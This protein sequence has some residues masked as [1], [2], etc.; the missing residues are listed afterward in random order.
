MVKVILLESY[1]LE[2]YPL[3]TSGKGLVHAWSWYY[4]LINYKS[5]Q[6][7]I[8]YNARSKRYTNIMQ[9][10]LIIVNKNSNNNTNMVNYRAFSSVSY[11]KS[12]VNNNL[13]IRS[14]NQTALILRVDIKPNLKL[15]TLDVRH[16]SS[17]SSFSNLNKKKL[18]LIFTKQTLFKHFS[19][20]DVCYGLVVI[21]I[22]ASIRYSGVVEI[23]LVFLFDSSPEWAQLALASALVLP[24][25]LGL[26][27][28]VGDI[29]DVFDLEKDKLTMG[30][31]KPN[32]KSGFKQID[33]KNLIGNA[34]N[35]SDS[36][37]G[38]SQQG[39]G[40]DSSQQ[41]QRARVR[42]IW[43]VNY[44]QPHQVEMMI[45]SARYR[46]DYLERRIAYLSN[47]RPEGI[48]LIEYAKLKLECS[49]LKQELIQTREDLRGIH[50][51]LQMHGLLSSSRYTGEKWLR[52]YREAAEQSGNVRPM[53]NRN[54][55]DLD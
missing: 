16:F 5:I 38:S 35:T 6:W 39:S 53:T 20:K 48:E 1:L 44:I 11:S 41:G 26:K 8:D 40:G 45:A 14:K 17:T 50:S 15:I 46:I 29:S 51:E 54:N 3:V 27:G 19:K 30:G 55:V 12:V 33:S 32:I 10:A 2:S 52:Y 43:N 49:K 7:L 36:G 28:V 4:G 23:I 47:L 34:M 25:K 22:I 42:R 9:T 24:L 18:G 37:G 31:D 21:I 13:V